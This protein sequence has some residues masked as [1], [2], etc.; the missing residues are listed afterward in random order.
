MKYRREENSNKERDDFII[1]KS[2]FITSIIIVV[3]GFL[4][5]LIA[6]WGSFQIT[7][8]GS[9]IIDFIC[10]AIFIFILSFICTFKS[11]NKTARKNIIT[12]IVIYCC[13]NVFT[14]CSNFG[15]MCIR[16]DREGARRRECWNNI[17]LITGALEMYNMDNTVMMKELD[18]KSLYNGGYLNAEFTFPTD[19]CYYTSI[20]DVTDKGFVC[21]TEHFCEDSALGSCGY[22][23]SYKDLNKDNY[24]NYLSRGSDVTFEQFKELRDKFEKVKKRAGSSVEQRNFVMEQNKI[25]RAKKPFLERARLHFKENRNKYIEYFYPFIVLFFPYMLHP[26]R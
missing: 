1:M 12:C 23:I 14:V 7:V 26:L 3:V 16:R 4:G 11:W 19:S 25:I 18:L 10:L 5:L 8:N 15:I 2:C 20:D 6:D 9:N 21:C 13:L 24:K 17:R 22:C